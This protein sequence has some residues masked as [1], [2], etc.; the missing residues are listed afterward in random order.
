VLREGD[1]G[2]R[3]GKAGRDDGGGRRWAQTLRAGRC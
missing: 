3:G 1:R 2:G